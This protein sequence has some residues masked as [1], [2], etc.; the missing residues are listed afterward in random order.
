MY[1]P[2]APD[3]LQGQTEIHAT[4]RG[5]LKDPARI[6][7]HVSLPSLSISYGPLQFASAQPIRVDFQNDVVTL[8]PAEF[9]GNG[10]DL[11]IQGSV[12]I[13]GTGQLNA[14][15]HGTVEMGLLKLVQKNAD[16]SG[17][18]TVDVE[19]RGD[20]AHPSVQ[21]KIQF[22]NATYST[23]TL[24][25]GFEKVNGNI[26]LQGNR[27]Q[28]SQFTAQAGGGTINASGFAILGSPMAIDLTAD[29]EDVRVRYPRGVRAVLNGK[30]TW[31]GS[32]AASSPWV[33]T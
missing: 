11:H 24:P 30:L 31:T 7:A 27:L 19:A 16:S 23:P 15:A 13:K 3:Q 1:V 29:A 28:I 5:P 14:S 2:G 22:A 20:L 26:E 17:Q 4:L 8:A 25:I 21:G 6:E 18:I 9:K 10:T 33:A 32:S 12:P